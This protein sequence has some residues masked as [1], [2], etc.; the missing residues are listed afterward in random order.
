MVSD[1]IP[2]AEASELEPEDEIEVAGPFPL[3]RFK[4]LSLIGSGGVGSVYCCR[5]KLLGKKVA[6]KLLRFPAR[7]QLIQ[8]QNEAKILSRLHHRNI[9]EVF[10]F[11]VFDGQMPY[12]VL[13]FVP[14]KSVRTVLSE[15]EHTSPNLALFVVRQVGTALLYAHEQNLFHRDIKP[16]NILLSEGE[17]GNLRVKVTDFGLAKFGEQKSVDVRHQ[18]LSLSGTPAYMAPEI[19][20]GGEFDARSE[21]YSIGCV[22]FEML[23]GVTPSEGAS[24]LPSEQIQR[25]RTAINSDVDSE[26][27]PDALE[28][29]VLKCL[30]ANV[31]ERFQSVAELLDAIDTCRL[32]R[33]VSSANEVSDAVKPVKP[34]GMIFALAGVCL[35]CIVIGCSIYVLSL[36][37]DPEVAADEYSQTA[38]ERLAS[39]DIRGALNSSELAITASGANKKAL[40]AHAVALLLSGKPSNA[41][42]DLDRAIS[43]MGKSTTELTYR[44]TFH[45]ALVLTALDRKAEAQRDFS[46]AVLYLP[47]KWELEKF[48][49]WLDRWQHPRVFPTARPARGKFNITRT[50]N[51]IH[52]VHGSDA[53]LEQ[54]VKDGSLNEVSS[55]LVR[56]GRYTSSGLTLLKS[57]NVTSLTFLNTAISD[58]DLT[59]LKSI[60]G[61]KVLV[62]V[63]CNLV[64]GRFL[65]KI[66]NL[67]IDTL[68]FLN[69]TR[70]SDD[71]LK[72]LR[73]FKKL[74]AVHVRNCA[75][76]SGAGWSS[77]ADGQIENVEWLPVVS[78]ASNYVGKAKV[79][80]YPSMYL[81][82]LFRFPRLAQLS[83]DSGS[84]DDGEFL[85]LSKLKRLRALSLIGQQPLTAKELSCVASISNLEGLELIG[86][87]ALSNIAALGASRQLHSLSLVMEYPKEGTFEKLSS[88]RIERLY[89]EARQ[90]PSDTIRN[91]K[92]MNSLKRLL[93][94]YDSADI[95]AAPLSA[96]LRSVKAG[97]P[98]CHVELVNEKPS[99]EYVMN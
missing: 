86:P 53:T 39:G 35:G 62:V 73:G 57:T 58:S 96:F 28:R 38:F 63:S 29:L 71:C 65:E 81:E 11:G 3:D 7:E 22:L 50:D 83:L 5:D 67:P 20:S 98:E 2:F 6:V 27:N 85:K 1:T 12:L 15:R 9:V 14:G 87:A 60:I 47:D 49:P 77:V 68:V 89:L 36:T 17:N 23:I 41:L 13:E 25:L 94:R 32:A 90:F 74:R 76:F 52:M 42:A 78:F 91:L 44:L 30:A 40:D 93:L 95:E 84:L 16:D 34:K 33:P 99:L 24:G 70:L 88:L 82:S 8:F 46:D 92:Q 59:A 54:L 75:S 18:T 79:S 69:M 4:P 31:E 45:R 61:L 37:K 64:D 97:L 51:Q 19:V 55:L 80:P 26:I 66:N 72:H 21:I 10:D 48:K 56:G 43:G